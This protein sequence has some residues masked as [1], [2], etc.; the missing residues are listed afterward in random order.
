MQAWQTRGTHAALPASTPGADMTN[1]FQR[2]SPLNWAMASE[3]FFPSGTSN[4][5]D[6]TLERTLLQG[7]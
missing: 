5:S 7:G 6:F 2:V 1:G 3:A 4:K